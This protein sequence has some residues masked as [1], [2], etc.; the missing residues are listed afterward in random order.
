M[1]R[2]RSTLGALALGLSTIFAAPMAQATQNAVPGD[3][4]IFCI[5]NFPDGY[6][7]IVF[8]DGV[9]VRQFES[10]TCPVL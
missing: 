9:P 8:V 1:K 10:E 6:I 4:V 2:I 3:P 5:E 7:V